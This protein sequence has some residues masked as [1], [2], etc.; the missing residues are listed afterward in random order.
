[1]PLLRAIGND[2]KLIRVELA[3]GKN[4]PTADLRGSIRQAMSLIELSME[5]S[6]E[7]VTCRPSACLTSRT[8]M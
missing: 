6:R 7:K 3:V 5:Q 1:M 2:V 4:R 8:L